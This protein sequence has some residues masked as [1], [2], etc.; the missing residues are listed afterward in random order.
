MKPIDRTARI[1]TGDLARPTLLLGAVI[2]F[3]HFADRV[4]AGLAQC[5]L[6]GCLP[7]N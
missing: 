2:A 7:W 3:W 6:Q 1:R 5:P 4:I